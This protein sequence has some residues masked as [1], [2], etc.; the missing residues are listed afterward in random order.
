ML[1]GGSAV[2]N[3]GL[4]ED[5]IFCKIIKGEIPSARILE[6]EHVLAFLDINPLSRGHCLIIPKDHGEKLHDIPDEYLKEILVAAKRIA[7]ALGASDYNLLQNNGPRAGQVVQ[8]AHFHLIPKAED[9]SGL[10]FSWT[11]RG[12]P[13]NEELNKIAEE[14]KKNL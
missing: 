10:N 11:P 2:M 13:S 14:I 8:H 12:K 6:T 9:G 7:L 4:A 1:R 3:V 5:C